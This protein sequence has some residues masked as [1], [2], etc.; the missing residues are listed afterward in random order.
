MSDYQ[1]SAAEASDVQ[2]LRRSL[3]GHD[4]VIGDGDSTALH[5]TAVRDGQIVGVASIHPEPM[6]TGFGEHAWRLHGLAVEHG[7]RG[8]G[9][10]ALLIER[11]LE[12]AAE[13]SGRAVWSRVPVGAFGFFD[14]YGFA[15]TGD[16]S[17]GTNGP[18]YLVYAEIG[19][20]RRSWAITE[21]TAG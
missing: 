14:R 19:P 21:P 8:Y 15:R 5:T 20:L 16:P 7:H 10:G 9:V 11:C 1:I 18:E 4:S 12:H 6:P 2:P 3:L 17:T 13:Q